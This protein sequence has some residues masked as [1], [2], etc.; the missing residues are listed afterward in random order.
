MAIVGSIVREESSG[1]VLLGG[2]YYYYFPVSP[3]PKKKSLFPKKLLITLETLT[4]F[5]MTL[6]ILIL[7]IKENKTRPWKRGL[8][9]KFPLS[10]VGVSISEPHLPSSPSGQLAIG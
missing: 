2:E 1:S 3:P 6:C 8:D 5:I 9:V 4:E 10:L 7:T